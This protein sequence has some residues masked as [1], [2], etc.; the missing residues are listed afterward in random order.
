MESSWLR[1]KFLFKQNTKTERP[2][3]KPTEKEWQS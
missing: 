2:Q 3:I 1:V